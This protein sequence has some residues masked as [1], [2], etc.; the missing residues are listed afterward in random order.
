MQKFLDQGLNPTAAA[1]QAKAAVVQ[2]PQPA[3]P[4]NFLLSFTF[5]EYFNASPHPSGSF[6]S[7][8]NP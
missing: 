6:S 3:E 7:T 4:R 2:D 5:K 8:K 1:I